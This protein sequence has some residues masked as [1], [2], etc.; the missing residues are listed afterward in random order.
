MSRK[1]Y[2]LIATV[3]K[4]TLLDQAKPTIVDVTINLADAFEAE[5]PRFDR[6][7]FYMAALGWIPDG[8]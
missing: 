8:G 1:D 5:N 3:I 7:K 6:K 2:I 4:M